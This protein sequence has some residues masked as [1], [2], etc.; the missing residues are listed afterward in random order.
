MNKKAIFRILAWIIGIFGV[1]LF[2]EIFTVIT[3]IIGINYTGDSIKG[4]FIRISLTCFN[5]L[6]PITIATFF[7]YKCT[8]RN[9]SKGTISYITTFTLGLL[10]FLILCLTSYSIFSLFNFKYK[11]AVNNML[12]LLLVL[13]VM[14]IFQF[15]N[16]N[17][18]REMT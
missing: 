6:I 13:V 7:Y 11:L 12:D 14:N 3:G 9:I 4:L 15:R 10:V 17:K 8:N 1:F 2:L 18:P 5:L 16:N